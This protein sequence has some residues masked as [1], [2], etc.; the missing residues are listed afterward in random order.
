MSPAYFLFLLQID[1]KFAQPFDLVIVGFEVTMYIWC[2]L[3]LLILLLLA[4]LLR[5][6]L[7][8]QFH[9]GIGTAV[10]TPQLPQ[11]S[12][13]NIA[14]TNGSV[15]AFLLGAILPAVLVLEN[16]VVE[17]VIVF[18]IL[19]FILFILIKKSSDLFPNIMLLLLGIDLCKT[20]QGHYVFVLSGTD[21]DATHV[22]QIGNPAKSKTYITAYKK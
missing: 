20:K 6:L 21:P 3:L 7:Y 11:F 19:Q 18:M 12:K 1:K 15:I 9:G 22:Y 13:V 5:M 10:M 8:R 2:A 4:L 16:S 14:E 17:S